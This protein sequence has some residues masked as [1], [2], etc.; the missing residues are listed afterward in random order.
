MPMQ[1]VQPLADIFPCF[2]I[3][4]RNRNDGIRN[5]L[6]ESIEIVLIRLGKQKGVPP[7]G[8]VIAV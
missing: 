3:V 6:Y 2:L 1:G 8:L 7:L 4:S 5:K